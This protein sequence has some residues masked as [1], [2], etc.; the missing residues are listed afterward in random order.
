MSKIKSATAT[1]L[2]TLFGIG[3]TLSYALYQGYQRSIS[4]SSLELGLEKLGFN[5]RNKDGAIVTKAKQQEALL[6]T[7]YFAGY[8][9]PEQLWKDI[10]KMGGI[11]D[12]QETFKSIYNVIVKSGANQSDPSKFNVKYL[13]KNLFNSSDLD[14]QDVEDLILYISQHAFDRKIGQERNELVAKKWTEQYKGEYLSEAKQLGLIDRE[15]PSLAKYDLGWIAG[16]SRIGALTR[17]EDYQYTLSKGITINGETLILAGQREL[18]ADI[19]GITPIVRKRLEKALEENSNIDNLDVSLP[20]G[21]DDA[22]VIEGREYML[23]L[24]GRLGIELD[25]DQPFIT[26]KTKEECPAGRFPDRTYPN[27]NN[28]EEKNKLTETLMSQDLLK[29]YFGNKKVEIVDTSEEKHVRPNTSTTARD[30]AENLVK[31][32]NEGEYGDKKPFVILFQTNQPYIERQTLGTQT[33]VDKVL[34]KYGLDKKGYSIKIEGVGF[35]NKQDVPVIHSELAALVAEKWRY[36]AAQDEALDITPK[37]PIETLL[38]Q[39]REND[40]LTPE[41]QEPDQP[42]FSLIGYFKE[43]FDNYYE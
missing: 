36:D 11:K 42:P 25:R 3:T 20:V 30:A 15:L 13:R 10:N 32:I 24:A 7:L 40:S 34:K 1:A 33:E 27:Y 31:R 5:G 28:K 14:T 8:F 4:P 17:L 26:Y 19:D 9:T 38:F 16:A 6:K 22:R 12:P 21:K 37:R 35:G 39:T 29:T 18:W 23:G 41:Y 2:L 43:T